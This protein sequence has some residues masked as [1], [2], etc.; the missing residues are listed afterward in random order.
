MG[1]G[2]FGALA[3]TA[4]CSPMI[5]EA[6]FT[7]RQPKV[8]AIALANET[9]G[10]SWRQAAILAAS[11]KGSSGSAIALANETDGRSWRQAAILA[12]S[13]KGSSGSRAVG[14]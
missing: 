4:V 9:D 11:L 2:T 6:S 3:R 10:R 7:S 12:A 14:P 5:G 13:L 1:G 8:A